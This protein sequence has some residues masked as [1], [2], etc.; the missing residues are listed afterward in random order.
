LM[1]FFEKDAHVNGNFRNI[2]VEGNRR[3]SFWVLDLGRS[4]RDGRRWSIVGLGLLFGNNDRPV[5]ARGATGVGAEGWEGASIARGGLARCL[6][7]RPA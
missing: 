5:V 6:Q 7:A 2:D 1:S 3:H 4:G